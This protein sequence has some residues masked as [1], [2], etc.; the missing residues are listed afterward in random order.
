[1][2]AGT[3]NFTVTATDSSAGTASGSFSITIAPVPLKLSGTLPNAIQ[4]SDYQVQILSANG[5]IAPYT[6]TSGTGS[7]PPGITFAGG[8][9][10]GNPSQAGT[11]DSR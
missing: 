8:Q 2:K 3:F 9:I 10:G 1:M 7:L 6:F 11:F 4:G 5:G